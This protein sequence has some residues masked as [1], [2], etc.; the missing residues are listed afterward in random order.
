M[1]FTLGQAGGATLGQTSGGTLGTI[2]S[3]YLL[4]G[5]AIP[6][7]IEEVA[8]HRT[9]TLTLRT[10]THI[11]IDRVRPAKVNENKIA[12][13]VTDDG[14]FAAVDRAGG[15]NTFTL[16]PPDNRKPLRQ[17]GD[18]HVTRYEENLVSQ[19]VDE[20][21][22]EIEFQRDADRTDAPTHP[23]SEQVPDT[24]GAGGTLGQASGFTMGG[25]AGATIGNADGV[26]PPDW[27]GFETRHGLLAT[28]RVD[29]QFIGTGAEGVERFEVVARFT[30][31]QAHVWEAALAKVDGSRIRVIKEGSNR[32]VDETAGNDNTVAVNAP[33]GEVV[34][35]GDY[36]ILGWESRRLNQGNAFQEI[37]W[38]MAKTP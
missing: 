23:V 3:E 8:T 25:P 34:A 16:D 5:Q 2:Q 7:I 1:G 20:W 32:V 28:D 12:V 29:A 38:T 26:V 30:F 36:V 4:D 19:A 10:P 33:T 14:G 37:R 24:P 9:L 13:L 31:D 11:L 17:A 21:T 15:P 18:Y 22:V 35:D 27:W 6:A